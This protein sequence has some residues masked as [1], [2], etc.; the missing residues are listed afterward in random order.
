[1]TAITPSVKAS[2]LPF[3]MRGCPETVFRIPMRQRSNVEGQLKRLF[4]T[5]DL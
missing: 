4:L 3:S 2:S 1:M 5:L